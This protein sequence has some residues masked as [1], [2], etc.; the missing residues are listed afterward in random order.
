M[1]DRIL[2]RDVLAVACFATFV[3]GAAW[4]RTTQTIAR[5][6]ARRRASLFT[7]WLLVA[8]LGIGLLERDLYP[9]TSWPLISWLYPR[10]YPLR[11][12]ILVDAR[13]A[14]HD[15]D[16]RA[17]EPLSADELA[18]WMAMRFMGLDSTRRDS[19]ARD[20]MRRATAGV[21]RARAGQRIGT[22]DRF[23]G[24]FSA[25]LFHVHPQPWNDSGALPPLPFQA[26]QLYV[27]TWD[28]DDG[29]RK[30]ANVPRK[31]LYEYR[32]VK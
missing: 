21:E 10:S 32:G 22:Y 23:L 1:I 17:W 3:G 2:V 19:V 27:E 13:G 25:P 28:P 15:I 6:P 18:S 14:E 16:G 9:F 31:L 4:S 12:Y 26:F 8:T 20:L 5:V 7:I 24:P 11:R 30:P 29:A